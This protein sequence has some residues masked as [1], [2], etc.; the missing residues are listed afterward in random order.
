MIIPEIFLAQDPISR[1]EVCTMGLTCAYLA[2]L[3]LL[4]AVS[5]GKLPNRENS[6]RMVTSAGRRESARRTLEKRIISFF[7]V[8]ALISTPKKSLSR[9]K[10]RRS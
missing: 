8:G 10:L 2:K 6:S 1:L 9:Q 5:N 3:T 4:T 7:E